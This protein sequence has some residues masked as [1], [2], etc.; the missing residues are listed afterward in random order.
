[1]NEYSKNFE[2]D[3]SFYLKNKDVFNFDG[4]I[5]Y[6]N[7]KG[8]SLVNYSENGL[9]AKESFYKYD[10][11]GEASF[12]KEPELLYQILKTKGS[13]NFHIKMW[14]EGRYDGTLPKHELSQQ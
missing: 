14:S 1:M 3:Y 8:E 11:N 10:S 4:S 12:C 5:Y 2:R 6:S 9:S 13:I 7:K